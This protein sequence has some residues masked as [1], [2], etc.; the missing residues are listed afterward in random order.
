MSNR[1][2]NTYYI[3]MF[4]GG[5]IPMDNNNSKNINNNNNNINKRKK[6]YSS[7]CAQG[8]PILSGTFAAILTEG[9]TVREMETLAIFL[10][11]LSNDIFLIASVKSK[12]IDF[13]Y[14]DLTIL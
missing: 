7:K 10:S 4:I 14:D 1:F 2:R 3:I 5:G 13:F 11:S 9:K 12:N 8:L 6:R